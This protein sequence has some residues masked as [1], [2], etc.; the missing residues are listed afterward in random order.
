MDKINLIPANVDEDEEVIVNPIVKTSTLLEKVQRKVVYSPRLHRYL[1]VMPKMYVLPIYMPEVG[2]LLSLDISSKSLARRLYE[3]TKDFNGMVT[4]GK[5]FVSNVYNLMQDRNRMVSRGNIRS[6]NLPED[7]LRLYLSNL[8]NDFVISPAI[9][10]KE[11]VL[12]PNRW[13][14]LFSARGYEF[15]AIVSYNILII[16]LQ[17]QNL[18]KP[19]VRQIWI[20]FPMKIFEVKAGGIT[21]YPNGFVK[22]FQPIYLHFS[23]NPSEMAELI[24]SEKGDYFL[25]FTVSLYD[26]ST[27]YYGTTVKTKCINIVDTLAQLV[28]SPYEILP[29]LFPFMINTTNLYSLIFKFKVK[30]SVFNK[31]L[32]RMMRFSS[33]QNIEFIEAYE[34]LMRQQNRMLEITKTNDSFI[35]KLVNPI[36]IPHVIKK[37]YTSSHYLTKESCR[38]LLTDSNF[39]ARIESLNERFSKRTEWLS[40]EFLPLHGIGCLLKPR[41]E[42]MEKFVNIFRSFY[43]ISQY[44]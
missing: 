44:K 15:R 41:A 24:P 5:I 20:N 6:F 23:S 28:F 22:Y 21:L 10:T 39:I 33:A 18:S 12:S 1:E 13:F 16:H 30:K 42:V 31:I 3:E 29:F 7:I 27:S 36:V 26:Y 8:M 40:R 19:R 14:L 9:V 43:T 37:L 17:K 4:K 35:V 38:E 34:S 32:A 11:G 2:V 25:C